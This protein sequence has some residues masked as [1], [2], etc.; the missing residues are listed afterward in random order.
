MKSERKTKNELIKELE[1]V[2]KKLKK[3]ETLQKKGKLA[4]QYVTERKVPEEKLRESE[5]FARVLLESPADS[6][7]LVNPDG[8]ILYTN[9]TFAQRMGQRVDQLIGRCTYDILPPELVE[10]RRAR[11]DE[12]VQQGTPIRFEDV[13]A[14]MH[15]DQSVYPIFDGEGKVAKIAIIARDITKYKQAEEALRAS[16]VRFRELFNHMSSGVAVYEAIDNGGDFIFRDFNPAAEKI[17]KVSKKDVLGKRV[18]ECFP[19][20]KA[21][22]VFEVFQRV[23]RTGKPEYFPQNI[24]NDERDPGSWRESWVFRLPSG[25]I[26]AIYNDVTERK[27]AEATLKQA[28]EWQ[29]AIFEGSRDAV[30]ISDQD[31]RFVAVN[32]AACDLTGYSRERLLKMRIPDVHDHPD[33]EAYKTYHHRIFGGEETL[34]E[35]KILRSD[36]VKVDVEFNNRCVSIAGKPYMHTTAR[37]IAARKRA[38]EVLKESEERFRTFV[39]SQGEGM[40]I[41]DAQECFEFVNPAAE[42]IFGVARGGLKGRNLVDFV[43]PSQMAIIEA[44]TNVRR[45]GKRSTYELEIVRADGETR[46]LIVTATPRLHDER[47]IGAF[48]AFRDITERKRAEEEL[49]KERALLSTIIETI[50]DEICLKDTDSRYIIA[51]KASVAALGA[52]SLEEMI[53]KTDLEYVQRDLALRLLAEEKQILESGRPS[54]GREVVRLDP[55]TGQITKCD[56]YTKVPV[57]AQDGTTVGL[58]AI[59]TDITQRKRAEEN[60]KRS[61]LRLRQL[62][63]HLESVREEERKHIAQEFHDQLGQTLTALKMDMSLMERDLADEKKEIAREALMEGVHSSQQLIDRGIQTVRAIMSELRPELLD[64]LGLVEALEWE[65]G[66]F[67]QRSGILCGLSADVGDLQFDARR[68]IALFRL[69]QESLTNV[70]RHAQAIGVDVVL[71]TEGDELILEIK[72]DGIGITLDAENKPRSFGLIGMRERAIFLGGT[73]EITGVKGKGTTIVVRMP[74]HEASREG[75]I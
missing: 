37:D 5:A 66:K 57:K 44:Q 55:T 3:L 9:R 61:E 25:E 46:Y 12:V 69:V 10:S 72:D 18:S 49:K 51:N 47:Y 64:Q 74:I 73:L 45:K 22:G 6:I 11:V 7:L 53:G 75:G 30:F 24:Y 68:S 50:P 14:G 33:L 34:S 36:R 32:N 4:E 42:T 54:I 63:A 31:S 15:L 43:K 41:V 71:R 19:G 28:L 21:F 40:G 8:I 52:K 27:Q 1:S 17:E 70:A 16:E 26:V 62:S 58:L 67:Q 38:E 23:W 2:R 13:R 59:N 60:M 35:A 48:G 29:K 20:V 65:V 56:L 39:E